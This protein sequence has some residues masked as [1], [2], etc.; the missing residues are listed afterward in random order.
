MFLATIC[1]VCRPPRQTGIPGVANQGDP[2]RKHSAVLLIA[3]AILSSSCATTGLRVGQSPSSMQPAGAMVAVAHKTEPLVIQEQGSFAVG[4]KV[5]STAG[6][7]NPDKPFDPAGQ[8]LHGDH[9]YVFYQ[10]PAKARQLPLVMWHGIGQFSKTWETTPDGRE[11]YQ[12]IFLRRDFSVYLIDQ[13][14]RG[15]AGRSTQPISL[16]PTPD[17]QGWFGTFRLGIWPDFFPGV[18]FSRDPEALNQYF[19]QMTPTTGPLDG[20]VMIRSVAALFDKVG[21][22]ILVTHSH[23]GGFGWRTAIKNK[24]V[25]AIVSYEPG[26]GFVFPEG[27][28]PAPIASAGG[29]LA[30]AGIPLAEFMLLTKIPIVIYYGDFI[31]KEPVAN[32]GQ[33]GWRARLEMARKWRDVVNKHGGDVTVVHLP[34]V[35]I[36]GNTHFP[37]SDLNNLQVADLMSTW[38]TKKGLDKYAKRN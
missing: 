12:N 10:I 4:G 34:E 17:E 37:F 13:P 23:S 20:D 36:K 19:R 35:G 21:P 3:V 25:R 30:A 2:M 7:F 38:L 18:Q 1:T 6:M 5:I 32:P 26:S 16:T 28:V 11:G 15:N 29:P 9:A 22:A 31:P 33:D 24:N 14:R 8:T 27:E